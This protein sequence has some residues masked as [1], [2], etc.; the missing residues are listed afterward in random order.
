MQNLLAMAFDPL[1]VIGLILMF[2]KKTRLSYV[3]VFLI[4][5][6][7]HTAGIIMQP[8]KDAFFYN[9]AVLR[10]FVDAVIILGVGYFFQSKLHDN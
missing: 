10:I 2:W 5:A 4:V 7:I 8:I 1:I 6:G 3:L 9:M